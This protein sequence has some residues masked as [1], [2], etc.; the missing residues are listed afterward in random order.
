MRVETLAANEDSE[1]ML[2]YLVKAQCN[3]VWTPT[4]ITFGAGHDGATSG[5]DTWSFPLSGAN[6]LS[7]DLLN[8]SG[9]EKR[10]PYV[11]AVRTEAN[12]WI[13]TQL[14]AGPALEAGA[15][16]DFIPSAMVVERIIRTNGEDLLE[17]AKIV[18][19]LKDQGG[20]IVYHPGG[21][22]TDHY[23]VHCRENGVPIAL[24]FEPVPGLVL[25]PQG[26]VDTL[27]PHAMIEG[28][29]TVDS[30][31]TYG[32]PN[33]QGYCQND[34][35]GEFTYLLLH[36][37]HNSV[38]LRGQNAFWIGVAAGAICKLGVA[39][40]EA[41]ARH[42]HNC[43]AG[44][45]QKPSIY[46]YYCGKRMSFL[47]ARLSRVTQ[48]LHYGWGKEGEEGK[49]GYGGIKW[50]LC[51]AALVPVFNSI[52][53]L[54]L[55]PTPEN[56][57]SVLLALNI[58]VNQAHNGG[59]WL[60]KFADV[61]AYDE[62]PKGSLTYALQI[63]KAL[64]AAID[65]RPAAVENM[66]KFIRRVESWPL[67]EIKPLRWRKVTLE[68]EPSSFTLNLKPSTVPTAR[69]ITIPATSTF[70]KSLVSSI[71]AVV[72]IGPGK[73]DLVTPTGERL[74]VWNEIPLVAEAR[75]CKRQ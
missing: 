6:P 21:S 64:K 60:N 16:P 30:L 49:V 11:E 74:N 40:M 62:I 5:K 2:T 17:W 28:L 73:I 39:A 56:A 34:I 46:G 47:R 45:K 27:D 7:K 20:V 36:A 71:G 52:K 15:S 33:N 23:S 53:E 19:A 4:L 57:S 51:G 32:R 22:L 59:W 63:G 35:G 58:A 44:M 50:A 1:I 31:N 55:K 70:V 48:L 54:V 18:R 26:Q 66:D 3:A 12:S 25:E 38:I 37:L 10:T 42:A 68:I 72:D 9:V 65:A 24:T 29:A 41:E 8:A 43:Y 67:T 13:I 61:K 69:K 14:R 75:E